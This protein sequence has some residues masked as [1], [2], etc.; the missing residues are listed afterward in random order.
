MGIAQGKKIADFIFGNYLK[1]Q[2][3]RVT[4]AFVAQFLATQKSDGTVVLT[5]TS[6]KPISM[7]FTDTPRLTTI[8]TTASSTHDAPTLVT[9]LMGKLDRG[10]WGGS[11]AAARSSVLI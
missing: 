7:L 4:Q 1:P 8:T 10:V 11:F 3:A 9:D 2:K 5:M 6:G